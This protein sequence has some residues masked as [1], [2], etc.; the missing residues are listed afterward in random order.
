VHCWPRHAPELTS[1]DALSCE[2]VND[3]YYGAA[4]ATARRRSAEQ[5]LAAAEEFERVTD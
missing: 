1:R 5:S 4:L 3:A 2:D